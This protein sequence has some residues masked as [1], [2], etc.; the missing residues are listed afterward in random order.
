[1]QILQH[2]LMHATIRETKRTYAKMLDKSIV[3]RMAKV[4]KK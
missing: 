2:I 1:M 3:E 4:D